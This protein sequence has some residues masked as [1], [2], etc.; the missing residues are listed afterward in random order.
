VRVDPFAWTVHGKPPSLLVIVGLLGVGLASCAGTR[1]NMTSSPRTSSRSV[2]T[3]TTS[4]EDGARFDSQPF[5]T[6]GH[7]ASTVETRAITALVK[8]Y[9]AA[10]GT[11][12]G[13]QACS[14]LYS[15]LARSVPEDY[16]K[17]PPAPP[18]LR[19]KTCSAVMS[20]VFKYRRGQPT[21]NVAAIE[22]TEVRTGGDKGIALLR[23]KQM[24]LGEIDAFHY[25]GRWQIGELLGSALS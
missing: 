2:A 13:A 3:T 21:L 6:F 15:P 24:K 11:Q 23:S 10:V 7:R 22:V 16:G 25:L 20:L 17:S 14:L 1:V 19:G 12:D 18:E 8:R 5:L 4:S 9:F